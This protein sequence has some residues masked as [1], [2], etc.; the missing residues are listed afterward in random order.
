MVRQWQEMFYDERY[1]QSHLTTQV[2]DYAQLAEA[3]GCAGFT[4]SAEDELEGALE[5]ALAAGRTAVVDVRCDPQEACFP[6]VP[7]GAAAVDVIEAPEEVV[8]R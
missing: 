4:V 5:A 2:P 7:A 3:Y 6:M 1:S 8:S